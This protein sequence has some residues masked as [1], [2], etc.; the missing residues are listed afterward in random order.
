MAFEDLDD[1]REYEIDYTTLFLTDPAVRVNTGNIVLVHPRN[2][3]IFILSSWYVNYWQAKLFRSSKD[4][5]A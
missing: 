5:R 4:D 3:I 2:A 1:D